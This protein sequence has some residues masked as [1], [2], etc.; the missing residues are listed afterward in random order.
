MRRTKVWKNLKFD[1]GD[2]VKFKEGTGLAGV[3]QIDLYI[4]G[5]AEEDDVVMLVDKERKYAFNVGIEYVKLVEKH[6]VE[7]DEEEAYPV[8][9]L[10]C[11]K[12]LTN[13]KSIARGYGDRCYA[14]RNVPLSNKERLRRQ[15]PDLT[16]LF[17]A[18]EEI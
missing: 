3:P 11:G 4:Y 7:F 17:G 15:L 5:F 16:N 8:Y 14:K 2:R 9:C 6:A 1:V 10:R 18:G 12:L 13:P